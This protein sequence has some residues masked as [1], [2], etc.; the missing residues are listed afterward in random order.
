MTQLTDAQAD[1]LCGVLD[2]V[3]YVVGGNEA[4]PAQLRMV[5]SMLINALDEGVVLDET[6]LRCMREVLDWVFSTYEPRWYDEHLERAYHKFYLEWPIDPP[7]YERAR[8]GVDV[9]GKLPDLDLNG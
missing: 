9:G 4:V 1:R 6:H 2:H 8:D 3:A 5:V 7:W